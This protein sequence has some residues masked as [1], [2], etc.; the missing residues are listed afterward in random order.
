MATRM[1]KIIGD[2][3]NTITKAEIY[4]QKRSIK[5]NYD[6]TIEKNKDVTISVDKDEVSIESFVLRDATTLFITVK[7]NG[8]IADNYQKCNLSDLFVGS[9]NPTTQPEQPSIMQYQ[10]WCGTCRNH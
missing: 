5:L 10:H 2:N 6:T 1:Y 9:I 8:N 3:G 7:C 4:N